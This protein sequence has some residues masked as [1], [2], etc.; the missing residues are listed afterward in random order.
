VDQE[1]VRAVHTLSEAGYQRSLSVKAHCGPPDWKE[2]ERLVLK[3]LFRKEVPKYEE[4]PP[5]LRE[6]MD[7][8]DI[9]NA[10]VFISQRL[11]ARLDG[12]R[13]W[14]S[15][16]SHLGGVLDKNAAGL[17]LPLNDLRVQPF[18]AWL[19]DSPPGAS[20]IAGKGQR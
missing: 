12:W 19:V 18:D 13:E 8:P 2:F 4:M 9:R 14:L 10:C 6:W 16:P 11:V 1:F 20:L 15:K 7:T 3:P 17:A 5:D